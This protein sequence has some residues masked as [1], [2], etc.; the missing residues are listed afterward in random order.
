MARLPYIDK[1]DL[2][3]RYRDAPLSDA[4]ITRVLCN[5]PNVAM[6][7]GG[8]ARYIRQGN[9]LDPRLRELAIIQVGYSTRN[10]YEYAHHV[11]IGLS[12]GVTD[13]DVRAIADETAG[14]PTQLEPLAKAAL[15]AAR[16]MT[17][18]LAV[19]DRTFAELQR[20]LDNE[21]LVELLFAIANYNAVVRLLASLQVD[22][23]D[24]YVQYLDR[25]PL[26]KA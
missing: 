26:P 5:S 12:F 17:H 16:E 7:S 14:R 2:P 10:T 8:V 19:T 11:Q 9:R 20:G 24:D 25:F 15:R 22:L 6:Q 18:D 4:N 3:P 1:N 13:D 23:E 21:C